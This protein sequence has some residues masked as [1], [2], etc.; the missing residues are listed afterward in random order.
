MSTITGL[1]TIPNFITE[2]EEQFLLQD[3]DAAPWMD[4]LQRRVQHYG[5]I[6]DYKRR[7]IE[8]DMYL[9]KLPDW[10]QTIA[11]RLWWCGYILQIPDQM[12][13]N[14]YLAG[15]GISPHVDCEPCF[16]DTILSLSLGSGCIMEFTHLESKRKTPLYLESRSLL[17]MSGEARYDWQHGIPARK[18]DKHDGY[19]IPR[20]RR[21]SLTFRKIIAA[22]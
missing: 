5:Y 8:R 10:G 2:A 22:P 21:V 17:V 4:T 13:V 12:I 9:G 1:S 20:K 15:Q 11:E 16:G 6:Y 7:T 18:S 14:E 19:L 3:I